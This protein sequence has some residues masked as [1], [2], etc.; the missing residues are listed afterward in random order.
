MHK[1]F[2]NISAFRPIAD[3]TRATHYSV[4]KHLSELLSPLTQNEYSLHSLDVPNRINSIF[5][6]VQENKEYMFVSLNVVSL[7][8][9]ISLHKTVNMILKQVYNKKLFSKSLSKRSLKKLFL[10]TCQK[11]AF[12]VNNKLYEQIDG[13]S[14]VDQLVQY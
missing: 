4:E 7:F 9:N 8:T 13:V 14:I 12:P 10:D 11:M 1:H 3:I 5:L 6:L 2:D